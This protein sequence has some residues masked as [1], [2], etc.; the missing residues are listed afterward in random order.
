MTSLDG[1]ELRAGCVT[2]VNTRRRC[3]GKGNIKRNKGSRGSL[4]FPA[5][6]LVVMLLQLLVSYKDDVLEGRLE[7]GDAIHF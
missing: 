1:N 5:A 2:A 6:A 7:L 3:I 4:S